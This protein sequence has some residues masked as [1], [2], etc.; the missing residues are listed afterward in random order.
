MDRRP[1]G[2]P[3]KAVA[4]FL[5]PL[6]LY[7]PTHSAAEPVRVHHLEGIAHG[8]LVLRDL[9]GKAIARGE[10]DQLVSG[11]DGVVTVDMNF[12]F[13]DG[14]SFREITKFTQHG[15]FRLVGDKTTQKGPSFK[16]ESESE[17][18]AKAGNITVRTVDGGKEK[19]TTKHMDLPPDVAN[20]LLTVLLKNL[21]KPGV[22]ATVSMVAVGSS[23]RLVHLDIVPQEETTL[24]YGAAVHK[25]EHFVVKI[26]MGGIAGV[27]APLMGKQPPDLQFWILESEVP[28]FLQSEGK[29]SADT[30]VWRIQVA[31]PDADSLKAL[32]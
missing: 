4:S 1:L 14:S 8:F 11:N 7:Y 5:I 23:P 2:W 19:V 15:E 26:R 16:Q 27:I 25:A 32:H 31:S 12:H 20:G 6:V 3:A 9:D 30:P 28:A 17:I 13:N 21:S 24:K 18:D 22:A 29:L 10:V